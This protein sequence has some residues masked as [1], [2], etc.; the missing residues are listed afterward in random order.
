MGDESL[1]GQEQRE[2]NRIYHEKL[3]ELMAKW[4]IEHNVGGSDSELS[5][6]EESLVTGI[7][8][9]SY[10]AVTNIRATKTVSLGL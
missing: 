6:D 3:L 9:F 4:N 7:S 5:T 8:R 1:D 10:F 2:R